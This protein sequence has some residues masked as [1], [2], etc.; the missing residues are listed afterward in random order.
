ML[1]LDSHHACNGT[2]SDPTEEQKSFQDLARKFAREEIAPAAAEL[3]R[4]G[5]YPWE[6]IRKSHSLGLLN[7]HIPQEYGGQ[8][9]R[10]RPR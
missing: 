1:W 10:Q 2:R 7:L 4:T 3:D 5:E 8:Q 6:L 9:P